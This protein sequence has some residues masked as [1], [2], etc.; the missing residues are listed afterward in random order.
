MSFRPL[1]SGL[2][3][4]LLAS[5]SGCVARQSE[6][7]TVPRVAS[8]EGWPAE[9]FA[10]P[11]DFAPSLPSGTESLRFAPGWRDPSAE[12]FWS[13]AFVMWIDAPAPDAAGIDH[14]IETYY[15]GL[16]NSFA[17][18]A[19]KDIRATPVRVDVALIA[20]SRY[21]ARMH[22]IDAFATFKP[23]DLRVLVDA[24]AQTDARTRL[25]I[26]VSPRPKE[27]EIW[28]S[29]QEAIASILADKASPP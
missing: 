11:P 12:D 5:L 24:V 23:I 14:L 6:P 1:A 21:E 9:T 26:R 16:L 3:V 7:S 15:N 19:E 22:A 2:L 13:Y 29:L 17:A 10:L 20:P 25:H 27:H 28:R 18:G 4:C 8:L